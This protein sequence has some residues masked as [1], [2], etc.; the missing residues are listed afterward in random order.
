MTG[1]ATSEELKVVQQLEAA[2]DLTNSPIEDLLQLGQLYIEP[3]HR[4][5]DAISLF[6]AVLQRDP[7]ETR[8]KFWLAYCYLHYL[9]DPDAIRRAAVLLESIIQTDPHHAGA[10]YMLLAEV[11]EEESHLT[12]DRKIQLLEASVSLEPDWV[13]NRENLAQAYHE[14]G[15][16]SDALEQIHKA[17]ANVTTTDPQWSITTRNFEESITGRIGYRVIERLTADLEKIRLD[18]TR[19]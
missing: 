1:H 9:M 16:F 5:A 7:A 4:E 13:Y 6:D 19:D 3:C 15:R 11:L 14:A 2:I 8:A 12:V 17:L 10:A 18:M